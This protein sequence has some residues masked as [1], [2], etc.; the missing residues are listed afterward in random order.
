GRC[1]EPFLFTP[2]RSS[3]PTTLRRAAA[4]VRLRGH[5][6]D[7]A[8]LE[9]GGLQRTDRGLATRAR[10]LHEHVDL[11]HAVLDGLAGGVLGGHLRGERRGLTR[12]LEADVAG[13]GPRDHRTV[14]VGDGDDRVVERAL[15]VSVP[16]GNILLL[17]AAHLLGAATAGWHSGDLLV[18]ASASRR[19]PRRLP[20]V[21]AG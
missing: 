1:N 18:S 4:V 13:R 21:G 14:R 20:G 15:D 8:D 2:P 12:A 6:L 5:V 9:A 11:L 10:A 7:G 19:R 3:D 17:F 16:V